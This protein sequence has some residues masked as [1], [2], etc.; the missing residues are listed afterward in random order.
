MSTAERH[1]HV[2]VDVD[3]AGEHI[4]TGGV[5]L[6]GPFGEGRGQ[7]R[8]GRGQGHDALAFH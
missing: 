6:L 2:G 1:L 4:T 3:G 5:Y 8:A 7:V